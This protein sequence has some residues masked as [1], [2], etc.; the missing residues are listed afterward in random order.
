M[1]DKLDVLESVVRRSIE[2]SPKVAAET[3]VD[4][5]LSD[6]RL[7]V[8]RRWQ[9]WLRWIYV[10]SSGA[11]SD[12][13]YSLFLGWYSDPPGD[14]FYEGRQLANLTRAEELISLWVLDG[15]RPETLFPAR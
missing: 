11:S 15:A 1:S 13:E 14:V 6:R 10:T 4:R 3:I 9:G 7:N 2:A 8:E 12:V 5:R